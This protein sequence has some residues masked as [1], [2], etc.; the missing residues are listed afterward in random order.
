MWSLVMGALVS[1]EDEGETAPDL[2]EGVSAR[3]HASCTTAPNQ[4]VG[5]TAVEA[6]SD[7]ACGFIPD[8]QTDTDKGEGEAVSEVIHLKNA[9]KV[10][11]VDGSEDADQSFIQ[12]STL[13][14]N[15]TTRREDGDGMEKPTLTKTP[16]EI[17]KTACIVLPETGV[18]LDTIPPISDKVDIRPVP[19]TSTLVKE[20]AKVYPKGSYPQ[21]VKKAK[22]ARFVP[23]EPYKAAVSPLPKLNKSIPLSRKT[24]RLSQEKSDNGTLNKSITPNKNEV[25]CSKTEDTSAQQGQ[26]SDD[27]TK[28][29]RNNE[30]SPQLEDNY[31][32]MLDIKEREIDRLRL[33]LAESEKQIRIQGQVN[34]ELKSLLVASV[35]EDIEARLD[36]LTQDKARLA[37]DLVSYNNKISRDWEE[38]EQLHVESDI[39][40]SKF[41]ASTV[42]LDEMTRSKQ[43]LDNRNQQLEHAARRILLER[44]DIHAKLHSI[45]D[46]LNAVLSNDDVKHK[47]RDILSICASIQLSTQNIC[48]K[49]AG[50]NGLKYCPDTQPEFCGSQ[51]EKHLEFLLVNSH[52]RDNNLPD[53]ASC[54][55]TRD[56]RSLLLKIGD[57]A[58]SPGKS[59]F[60]SCSHCNGVVETV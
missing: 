15:N 49:L 59:A 13:K 56:A 12:T 23:C 1:S 26:N 6:A 30:I 34:N 10:E 25:D 35:G 38:K 28:S 33:A 57:E 40:R 55:L 17:F 14:V 7:Q 29:D 16:S 46:R 52:R 20:M 53:Q 3:D 58:Q 43:L 24:S 27:S 42:I 60:S 51:A 11:E 39:W 2:G 5:T 50:D 22:E 18:A 41:L 36:F 21:A 8:G 48:D 31:R 19:P 45:D 44:K 32:T 47:S 4:V 9:L 37:A 54:T